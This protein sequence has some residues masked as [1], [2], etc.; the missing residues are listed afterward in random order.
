MV[1]D[2]NLDGRLH[3]CLNN[4]NI[5]TVNKY[6]NRIAIFILWQKSLS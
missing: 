1:N 5:N 6:V 3:I 2:I 4:V